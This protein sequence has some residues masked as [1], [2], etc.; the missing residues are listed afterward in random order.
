MSDIIDDPIDMIASGPTII[1]K[2]NYEDAL[3]I[4]NKY[5]L[6]LSDK[7][8][9]HLKMPTVKILNNSKVILG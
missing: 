5:K 4:V 8:L 3:K 1:D 7:A 2:S 6:V 9:E